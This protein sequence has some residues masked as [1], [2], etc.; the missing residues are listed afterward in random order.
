MP[1]PGDNN[2]GP[3]MDGDKKTGID[4]SPGDMG[5]GSSMRPKKMSTVPDA[6]A[7]YD[8]CDGMNQQLLDTGAGLPAQMCDAGPIDNLGDTTV[9]DFFSEDEIN[10]AL[11]GRDASM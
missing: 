8:V 5:L 1:D 10:E 11:Y 3:V 9:R 7:K 4:E 2:L 6:R